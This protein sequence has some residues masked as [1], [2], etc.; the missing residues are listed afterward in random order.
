MGP[1]SSLLTVMISNR[2]L[3]KIVLSRLLYEA[4]NFSQSL[5]CIANVVFS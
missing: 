1:S 4:I 3:G 5:F 2:M